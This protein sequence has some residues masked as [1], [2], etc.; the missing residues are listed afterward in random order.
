[1]KRA[2]STYHEDLI[3]R[4]AWGEED[5]KRLLNEAADN[6][7]RFGCHDAGERLIGVAFI[8]AGICGLAAI[9]RHRMIGGDPD[10]NL[11]L[12][13]RLLAEAVDALCDFPE[14]PRKREEPAMT[15]PF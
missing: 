2:W 9:M 5:R 12:A 1:V 7:R 4:I 13:E 15:P 14:A 8:R 10:G 3:E 11:R 6:Y